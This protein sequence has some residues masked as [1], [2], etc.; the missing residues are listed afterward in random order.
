M[1]LRKQEVTKILSCLRGVLE[2]KQT[3]TY[4]NDHAHCGQGGS[5]VLCVRGPH[6]HRYTPCVQAAVEGSNQLDACETED[7]VR[8]VTVAVTRELNPEPPNSHAQPGDMG[9][10]Y[11]A[12]PE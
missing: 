4:I 3:G 9:T 6:G 8:K 5:K 11:S 2:W 10:A 1:T 12:S 7:T